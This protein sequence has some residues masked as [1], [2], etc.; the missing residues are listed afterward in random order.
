MSPSRLRYWKRTALLRAGVQSSAEQVAD[1]PTVDSAAPP[2]PARVDPTG[3]TGPG[4]RAQGFFEFRD[5]VEVRA[6]LRLIEQGFSARRIRQSLDAYHR[7]ALHE[8]ASVNTLH[9]PDGASRLVVR[10]EDAWEEPSGQLLFDFALPEAENARAHDEVATLKARAPEA[11]TAAPRAEPQS[12]LAWF[13]RGCELDQEPAAFD[14]ALAAYRRAIELDPEFADAHCNLGTVH[15]NRSERAAARRAYRRALELDPEH[16]E[17]NFNLGSL[18]EEAGRRHAALRH[19]EVAVRVAPLF[20]DARLNLALLYE[21]LKLP[22]RAH[23]QWRHYLQ[24]V[25]E[26]HWADL[27]RERLARAHK[28]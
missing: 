4:A 9:A 19:Y 17:A 6:L 27:A 23:E 20:G 13:E 22:R 25:P 16:L 14:E 11:P 15:F 28:N 18:L 7:R 24:C 2:M 10:R 1:A 12:A 21:K 3:P 5:L 8:S 26:G